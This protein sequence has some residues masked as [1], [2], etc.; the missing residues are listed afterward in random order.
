MRNYSPAEIIRHLLADLS[1]GT[2][3]GSSWPIVIAIAQNLPDAQIILYDTAGMK[4]GRL[5]RTGEII[6]H[7]GV[8]IRVRGPIYPEAWGKAKAISDKLSEVGRVSVAVNTSQAY[9]IVSI[10]QT[11]DIQPIGLVQEGDRTNHNFTVNIT[12]TIEKE[13]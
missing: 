9:T 2:L 3:T 8:Q 10:T 1:L 5:M 12:V 11:G 4:D 13:G 6:A 7:P